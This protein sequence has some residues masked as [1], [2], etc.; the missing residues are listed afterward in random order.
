MRRFILG[1]LFFLSSLA[2]PASAFAVPP[3]VEFDQQRYDAITS[4][5]LGRIPVHNP[6]WTNFNDGDTPLLESADLPV[7]GTLILI[8]PPGH[9]SIEPCEGCVELD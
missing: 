1:L 2:L 8:S 6:E 3:I 5:A 4:Q 9:D 7:L